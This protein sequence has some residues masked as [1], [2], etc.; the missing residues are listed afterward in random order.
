MNMLMTGGDPWAVAFQGLDF[1]KIASYARALLSKFKT[2]ASWQ[3]ETKTAL[4]KS[5]DKIHVL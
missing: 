2:F 1:L 3:C 5:H 4:I